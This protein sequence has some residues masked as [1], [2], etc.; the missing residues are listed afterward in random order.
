MLGKQW[1]NR[2][3]STDKRGS[4]IERSHGRQRKLNGI[5]RWYFNHVMESLPLML[6]AALLLLGC[7]LSRY[8]WGIDTAIAL[9]VLCAT[10]FGAFF[11]L[12]IVIA[13]AAS[14]SFPYQTPAAHVSRYILRHLRDHLLPTLR[15]IPATVSAVISSNLSYL[16]QVSWSCSAVFSWWSD[17]PWI[18][19]IKAIMFPVL[20]YGGLL[21]D[22]CHIGLVMIRSLVASGIRVRRQLLG[23]HKIAYRWFT[24]ITSLRTPG[25]D[26]QTII[27]D[28]RCISWTL[29]TSLD[30]SVHLSAFRHLTSMPHLARFHSTLVVDCFNIFTRCISV[31]NGK[32]AIIQGFEQLATASADAFFRILHYLATTDPNSSILADLQRHYKEVFPSEL[33]FTGLPFDSTMTEIHN[34]AGRFGNPRDIRW[35]KYKMSTQEHIPFAQHMLQTAQEG[36]ERTQ[37]RKVPRWILRSALY[38]L[39]LGPVS[40]PP[41]VADCLT[42][43]ATDLDCELPE[44]TVSDERCV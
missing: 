17:N 40:Q 36:Y 37:R 3:E 12:F 27:M 29:Q 1:L 5:V 15:S 35:H 21:L 14:E 33:D 43:V 38:F 42:I 24:E 23:S 10:S 41:V 2:Y 19:I 20:L 34:L 8:L 30:K 44:A 7:A 13:G 6:Q 32:V 9:V 28:L 11:Y 16:Y 39:S 31:S 22:G 25:P 18:N 4:A 26:Q